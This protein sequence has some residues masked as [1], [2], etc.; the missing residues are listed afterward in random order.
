MNGSHRGHDGRCDITSIIGVPVR[1]LET[2]TRG[3]LHVSVTHLVT[4]LAA[5]LVWTRTRL[6]RASSGVVRATGESLR[7]YERLST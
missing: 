4:A 1:R 5:M 6:S 3:R 7:S 2:S